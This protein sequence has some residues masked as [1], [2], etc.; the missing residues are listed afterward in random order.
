MILSAVIIAMNRGKA[1]GK[2]SRVMHYHTESVRVL[3]LLVSHSS[4][5]FFFLWH[6][7]PT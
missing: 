6:N 5:G 3:H 4:N 7:S 2:R 1:T